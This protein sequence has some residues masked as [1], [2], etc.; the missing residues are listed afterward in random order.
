[1]TTTPLPSITPSQN[2]VEDAKET[3]DGKAHRS[4]DQLNRAALQE[5]AT[6]LNTGLDKE[7]VSILVG[8]CEA[9]V[10]PE[11][12]AAAIKELRR[13]ATKK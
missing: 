1:M 6:L 10:N 13:E 12:L 8:L 7:A 5:I 4:Q 2:T 9:G 11:A 3:M